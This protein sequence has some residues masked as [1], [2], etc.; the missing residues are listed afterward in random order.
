MSNTKKK[1]K[2]KHVNGYI[3]NNY[4]V[5]SFT[6]VSAAAGYMQQLNILELIFV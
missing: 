2:K 1:T 3:S 5:T 6:N 4:Q